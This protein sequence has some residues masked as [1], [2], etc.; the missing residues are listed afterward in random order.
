LSLYIIYVSHQVTPFN[1]AVRKYRSALLTM[2]VSACYQ[3]YIR[4]DVLSLKSLWKIRYFAVFHQI[5]DDDAS[6]SSY[7]LTRR[8]KDRA[9]TWMLSRHCFVTD[10]FTFHA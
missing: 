8:R 4:F 5:S 2:R 1:R 3:K 6:R 10:I 9:P 7:L